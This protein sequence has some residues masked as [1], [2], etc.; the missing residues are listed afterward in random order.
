MS[1]KNTLAYHDSNDDTPS[2][3]LYEDVFDEEAVYLS[4]EG[5]AIELTAREAGSSTITLRLPQKTATQLGLLTENRK[6]TVK[7]SE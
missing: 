3:H 5:V 7:K 2:W 6:L 4:L 1:T